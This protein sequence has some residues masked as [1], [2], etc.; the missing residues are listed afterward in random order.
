MRHTKISCLE[1]SLFLCAF[2]VCFGNTL[3]DVSE[4]GACETFCTH[5]SFNFMYAVAKLFHASK[6]W[7]KENTCLIVMAETTHKEVVK[8]NLL[9]LLTS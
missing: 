8:G 7:K 5:L 9:N 2:L 1:R 6:F 3:G 4:N